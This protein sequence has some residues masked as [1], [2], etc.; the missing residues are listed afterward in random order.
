MKK[1]LASMVSGKGTKTGLVLALAAMAFVVLGCFGGGKSTTNKPLPSS[2]YGSWSASDGTT[3][4]ITSDGIGAYRS[5][6][7]KVDGAAAELD[8]TGNVLK[9]SFLGVSVKEFQIN[10]Q[11]KNGSMKLDGVLY[12]T[13]EGK[14]SGNDASDEGSGDNTSSKSG[15]AELPS[16][17]DMDGMVQEMV[18]AVNTAVQDED[19]DSF[20]QKYGSKP[21]IQQV[22]SKKLETE[23]SEF[24]EKKVVFNEVLTS[25]D[26]L[27][28]TYSS[29][30]NLSEQSGYKLLNAAGKFDTTPPTTFDLQYVWEGGEWKLLK[31]K[32]RVEKSK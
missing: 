31:I 1:L 28:P 6:G 24:I 8:E 11:P 16:S 22:S 20:R 12:Y 18:L 32:I 27:T 15:T 3:L 17:S 26:G 9:L 10:Q 25:V 7:T 5:G 30:P 21:F 2:F 4:R 14:K 19:F 29:K 23:F 13:D